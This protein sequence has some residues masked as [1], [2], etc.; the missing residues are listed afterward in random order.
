MLGAG[1]VLIDEQIVPHGTWTPRSMARSLLS[2]EQGT[3][4]ASGN[5]WRMGS[6]RALNAS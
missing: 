1:A 2:L 4:K 3:S 6:N 5:G